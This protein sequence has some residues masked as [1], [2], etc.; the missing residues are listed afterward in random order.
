MAV[1]L[2]VARYPS[3]QSAPAA[4]DIRLQTVSGAISYGSVAYG[5]A[6]DYETAAHT[7]AAPGTTYRDAW[8]AYDDVA[9]EYSDVVVSDVIT[10]VALAALAATGNSG[11]F[12]G[13]ASAPATATLAATGGSGIFVGTAFAQATA[14]AAI[15]GGS[16]TFSGA[17]S[18]TAMPTLSAATYVPGSLTSTGF[19][20]RVT[21]TWP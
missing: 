17:A 8:V 5:S 3:A 14:A 7:S 15:T 18:V 1:T 16:G 19:R 13:T 9:D 2:Y 10:T 11:T 4:A 21:V 6:G 12:S 20:P